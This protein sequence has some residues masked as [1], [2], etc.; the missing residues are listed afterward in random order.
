MRMPDPNAPECDCQVLERLSKEPDVPIVYDPVLDEYH[1]ESRS[2]FGKTAIHH[3]FF[4]GGRVPQS[5]RNELFMHVT[6]AESLRIKGITEK[7]R[8]LPEILAALGPPDLDQ[9]AGI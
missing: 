5:R 1:I 2:G 8:T 7:L 6:Q 4:C 3:C 9:P